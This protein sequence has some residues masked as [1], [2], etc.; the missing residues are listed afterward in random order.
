MQLSG[1]IIYHTE[2]RNPE[3]DVGGSKEI[4]LCF[5]N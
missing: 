5:C 4:C 1:K 2:G 3:A